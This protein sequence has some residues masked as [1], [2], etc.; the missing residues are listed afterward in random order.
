MKET[1][2]KPI[3]QTSVDNWLDLYTENAGHRCGD[4]CG[5]EW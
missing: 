3:D 4:N 2:V 5:L 1:L